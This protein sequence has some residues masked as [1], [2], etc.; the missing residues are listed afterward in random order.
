MTAPTSA[1]SA[2]TGHGCTH[3]DSSVP[4]EHLDLPAVVETERRRSLRET[5]L[6][7]VV[8]LFL[9]GAAVGRTAG[10]RA[11]LAVPLT[12]AAWVAV[13]GLGLL[14]AGAVRNRAGDQRAVAAGAL[15]TAG[16]V[17]LTA[18]GVVLVV[19]D[20]L[21]VALAAGATWLTVTAAVHAVRT[22]AWRRVLVR[23]TAEGDKAR[24]VAVDSRE[25]AAGRDLLPWAVQG[26]SVG[27]ATYL[28]GL[29]PLAAVVMVP[30][31]VVLAVWRA[32]SAG[33]DERR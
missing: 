12:V 33:A 8:A 3:C 29:V 28:L 11:L 22:R 20:G 18:L 32:R 31:A 17:P 19:G 1:A 9:L 26:L 2:S 23:G 21:E 7:V 10:E 30:L 25:R 14:V 13:T 6:Q 15:T 4:H 24:Q 27:L 5:L 16:L